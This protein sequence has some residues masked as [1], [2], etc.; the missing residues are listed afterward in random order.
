MR[1]KDR[2]FQFLKHRNLRLTGSRETLVECLLDASRPL[3]YDDV[4][5]QLRMDKATF[6][7]NMHT[8]ES[9]GLIRRI[10]SDDKKWYFELA[11]SAHAHFVCTVCHRIFC[12][13]E[14]PIA[15]P[16]GYSVDTVVYKGRCPACNA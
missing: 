14:L 8:F 6:Y 1:T 13:D 2:I 7:R 11:D 3:C 4:R 10:E 15:P 9:A 16:E 12:L 5:A